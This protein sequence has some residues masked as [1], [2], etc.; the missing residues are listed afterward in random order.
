MK[1][2]KKHSIFASIVV[3]NIPAF[4]VYVRKLALIAPTKIPYCTVKQ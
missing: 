1:E 4:R 3:V 2:V